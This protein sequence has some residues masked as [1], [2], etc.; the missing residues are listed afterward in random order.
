M[1]SE[2]LSLGQ[3][4]VGL[5]T[6]RRVEVLFRSEVRSKRGQSSDTVV[7][8]TDVRMVGED[9][10]VVAEGKDVLNALE[11]HEVCHRN[12]RASEVVL[13]AE[14]AGKLGQKLAGFFYGSLLVIW[15]EGHGE[16]AHHVVLEDV[17]ELDDSASFLSV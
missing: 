7:E 3:L 4:H 2:S 5:S 8:S 16:E 12:L 15:L 6:E 1:C 13:V 17:V 10:L 11:E 14:P 9:S